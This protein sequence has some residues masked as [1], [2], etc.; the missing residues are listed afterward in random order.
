MDMVRFG[1]IGTGGMGTGHAH[2]MKN[3]EEAELTAVCDIDQE[4]CD[5]VSAEFEV[6]GFTEH[7][8]LI[9]SGLVDAVIVATPHYFHPPISIYA[10]KKGVHVLSEKPVAVT[11]KAADEMNRTAEETGVQFAVMY[12][13]RTTPVY[14]AV[15]RL[16]EEGRLGEIYR[17]CRIDAGFRS[18]AYYNSAGWRATW[19]GEGGGVLINQAPHG[20]DA[21]TSLAG[22]PA[23]VI[24][25]TATRRHQI[26]V[27]D[28]ASAM[29]EYA[30]GAIGFYHT[31]VTEAPGTSYLELA[32]EK[33]KLVLQNGRLTLWS[34]ETPVQVFSDTTD[35]MWGKPEAQQ[36]E[37]P[38]E[39][40]PSGHGE[41]I[42]NLVRAILYNEPLV[43]PGVEGIRSVEFI[44]AL[45]LSGA[46]GKPVNIPVDREAYEAFIGKKKRTSKAKK[47]VG[48]TLRI[49]DP[50]H[51]T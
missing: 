34:L 43:S 29:L 18:Q 19:K 5:R 48:P 33:G 22:L 20:I 12:Q 2:T 41:V 24:A 35:Q 38:L 9:D 15:R 36:E 40:R 30:N 7:E 44:N 46:T 39:E 21:F 51:R 23:R 3:V 26:E 1:I 4:V 10:M 50:Q 37:I 16:I 25:R 17:T 28:E 27:E 47:T 31:S 6:P 13:T 49:T 45:L 8:A 14:Q 42:R 32:G 11:V